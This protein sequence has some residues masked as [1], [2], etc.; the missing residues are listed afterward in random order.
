MRLAITLLTVLAS[1]ATASA[2]T[3]YPD[4]DG[5][6]QYVEMPSA[7]YTHAY[8]GEL[9]MH[10]LSRAEVFDICRYETGLDAPQF[11]G[12]AVTWPIACDVY[13]VADLLEPLRGTVT[14]HEIA[15]CNGWPGDHPP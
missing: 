5:S 7:A 2:F 1:A 3:K 11:L 8:E 6:W 4:K 12:C 9:R 14:R 15:H 13:V 10:L